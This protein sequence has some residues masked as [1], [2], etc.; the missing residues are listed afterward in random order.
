ML[1]LLLK[2]HQRPH[3]RDRLKPRAC[4]WFATILMPGLLSV[5]T[6]QERDIVESTLYALAF[7]TLEHVRKSTQRN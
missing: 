7:V 3:D 5:A 2:R 4:P 1:G 6:Q